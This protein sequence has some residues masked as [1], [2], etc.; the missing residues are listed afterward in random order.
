MTKMARDD[1]GLS[2]QES[3]AAALRAQG[4]SQ[5]EAYRIAFGV[6]R[7]KPE[8]VWKRASDLFKRPHVQGRVRA[9][10]RASKLQDMVS[11][12]EWGDMTL[13]KIM[14]AEKSGNWNAVMQ[15]L[16]LLGQGLGALRDNFAMT[17]EA[18][19]SDVDLIEQLSGSDPVKLSALQTVLGAKD[20]FDA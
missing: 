5:S 6:T 19:T 3:R 9:L 20:T 12:G 4:H 1:D 14:K 17:I 11:I 7:A 13:D 10:L 18:R 8:T 16:R 15:G 2:P